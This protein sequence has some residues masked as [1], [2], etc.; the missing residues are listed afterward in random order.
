VKFAVAL[1]IAVL[2]MSPTSAQEKSETYKSGLTSLSAEDK[3]LF[4]GVVERAGYNCPYPGPMT[5][6]GEDG[7]GKIFRL[8]C[9]AVNGQ[10][11]TWWDMRIIMTDR[12]RVERW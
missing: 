11:V 10:D 3:K 7:R 5:E 8:H 12:L 1:V 4:R 2:S 9:I 6:E